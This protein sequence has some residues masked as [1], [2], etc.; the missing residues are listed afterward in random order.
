MENALDIFQMVTLY[1]LK[2]EGGFLLVFICEH[3]EVAKGKAQ[4]SLGQLPANF[5]SQVTHP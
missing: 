2:I 3:D 1:L 5:N 4:E